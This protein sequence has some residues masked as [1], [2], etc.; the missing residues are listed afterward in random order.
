MRWLAKPK[1][2]QFKV[3]LVLSMVAS[4]SDQAM[5]H[6][7]DIIKTLRA[8]NSRVQ[9]FTEINFEGV[10]LSGKLVRVKQCQK[11]SKYALAGVS[12]RCGRCGGKYQDV[13][14]QR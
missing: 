6:A 7:D 5:R 13:L 9:Y 3:V 1:K 12:K 10:R 11:C 14:D 2:G 8:W 4:S